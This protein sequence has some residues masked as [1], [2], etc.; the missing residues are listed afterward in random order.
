MAPIGV[1]SYAMIFTGFYAAIRAAMVQGGRGDRVHVEL[2]TEPQGGRP[3]SVGTVMHLGSTSDYLFVYDRT[4]R[5]TAVL[6]LGNVARITVEIP[7]RAA[8]AARR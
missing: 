7:G 5:Q 1:V 4:R 3:D 6:P 8:A 2:M